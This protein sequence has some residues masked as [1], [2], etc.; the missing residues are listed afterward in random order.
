[1]SKMVRVRFVPGGYIRTEKNLKPVRNVQE[2]RRQ[3]Q[4][5]RLEA[6]NAWIS[7]LP[8]I[9]ARMDWL[10]AQPVKLEVINQSLDKNI[11]LP[12]RLIEQH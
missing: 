11:V 9:S 10:R 12:A 1:M 4:L 3:K 7:V 8:V 5:D 6:M 2:E